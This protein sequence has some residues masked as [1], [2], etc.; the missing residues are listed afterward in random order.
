MPDPR[1]RSG[2]VVFAG[3][4][5]VY[6]LQRVGGV[7]AV[8]AGISGP[9]YRSGP[10]IFT[11]ETGTSILTVTAGVPVISN[12]VVSTGYRSGPA[13][14]ADETGV[15]ILQRF[16]G[17]LMVSN[18]GGTT[19]S[20]FGSTDIVWTRTPELWFSANNIN[21]LANVGLNNNDPLATWKNLGSL[22]SGWDA[23]QAVAGNKPLFKSTAVSGKMGNKP[24]VLFDGAD[25]YMLSTVQ[26]AQAQPSTFCVVVRQETNVTGVFNSGSAA[27]RQQLFTVFGVALEY[28]LFASGS[29]TT[30]KNLTLQTFHTLTAVF[31]GA[32]SVGGLDGSL[33]GSINPGANTLDQI[34]L[35]AGP[36]YPAAP[37]NCYLMQVAGFFGG[38]QPTHAQLV[39]S[40]AAVYGAT[41]Q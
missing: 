14:F 23:L 3:E 21:G 13:V 19:W 24:G 34:G 26:T 22:G 10:L 5:G 1:Y 16:G 37:A 35:G 31:N 12:N 30:L 4:G 32:S 20:Q 36:A 28:F 6:S 8:V 27:N 40:V 15:S 29:A 2:P 7:L 38:S 41:P 33:S 17:A 9:G 18:D 39:A 11:D 25:D